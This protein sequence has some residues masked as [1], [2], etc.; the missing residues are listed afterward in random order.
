[1]MIGEV[2]EGVPLLSK[3]TAPKDHRKEVA[4][5]RR[6]K[7]KYGLTKEQW[8][9]IYNDQN[10]CCYICRRTEKQI[11]KSKSKYLMVD[12][13]HDTNRVR[14]L[15]CGNCNRHVLPGVKENVEMAERLVKYLKEDRGYGAVPSINK[16]EDNREKKNA[17]KAT[18]RRNR[19]R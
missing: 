16:E 10:G 17:K 11:R 3:G 14:G 5:W 13:C 19:N 15:L 2:F 7:K 1:M 12:H 9:K 6:I 18:S 4:R 8:Y